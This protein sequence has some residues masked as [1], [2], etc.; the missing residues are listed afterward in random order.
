MLL[1]RENILGFR[2]LANNSK[3]PT[4]TI[5]WIFF[6]PTKPE[7]IPELTMNRNN[8]WVSTCSA[9]NSLYFLARLMSLEGQSDTEIHFY[10]T[11]GLS[12]SQDTDNEGRNI[13][14]THKT[15]DLW[16]ERRHT[17]SLTLSQFFK[18]IYNIMLLLVLYGRC[19]HAV[20]DDNPV[21]PPKKS[22]GRIML[23]NPIH[24]LILSILI[25]RFFFF[26]FVEWDPGNTWHQ[27]DRGNVI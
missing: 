17:F 16:R 7:E 3:I 2:L 1:R 12:I 6:L 26:Y 18:L 22:C 15:S 14:A 10:K 21:K 11:W 13:P 27:R 19:S 9:R 25:P 23:R 8:E 24:V 20:S 5:G 4:T